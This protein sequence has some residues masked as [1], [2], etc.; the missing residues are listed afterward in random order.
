VR[1]ELEAFIRDAVDPG[2]AVHTDAWQGYVGVGKL[3]Y[4]H[5]VTGLRQS[6]GHECAVR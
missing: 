3:G 6:P 2:S 4:E 1:P 5:L